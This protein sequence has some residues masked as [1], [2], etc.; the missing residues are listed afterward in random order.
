MI[1]KHWAGQNL[2]QTSASGLYNEIDH[3]YNEIDQYNEH[4]PC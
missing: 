4:I 1:P 2:D 3:L